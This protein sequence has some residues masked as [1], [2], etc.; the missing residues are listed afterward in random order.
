MMP[1]LQAVVGRETG[2]KR[3]T[4]GFIVC[5][6]A[7]LAL[8]AGA[9]T[10]AP[11]FLAAAQARA[12]IVDETREKYFSRLQPME[13]AAKTGRPLSATTL[14]AQRAETRLRYKA[15]VREFS[16]AEKSAIRW[17]TAAMQPKL[18]RAYPDLARTPWRFIKVA[19][20]IEGG[21]PHTRGDNI[22]LSQS[23]VEWLLRMKANEP[24]A[25][26]LFNA[27]TILVHELVHVH[28]RRKP[29]RYA[30]LY[31]KD[32]GFVKAVDIAIT[33]WMRTYQLM[34]PDGTD[35][36]WV[37]PVRSNGDVRWILPLV[38]F[39]DGDG[40][41]RMPRDMRLIAVT[42]RGKAGRFQ[43]VDG[44]NG[45]DSLRALDA[46]PEFAGKFF[47][48]SSI[49]HPNEIAADFVGTLFALDE[50][51]PKEQFSARTRAATAQ[52]FAAERR[53]F[54]RFYR[55]SPAVGARP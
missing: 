30:D 48:I 20:N 46:V 44:G 18:E 14:P 53:L 9:A 43:V 10:N 28:Q 23:R 45:G 17:Y 1:W 54:R 49:F 13:M 21:L 51:F 37:Y 22:I 29:K 42:L 7:N 26:A 25:K 3:I 2:M 40:P 41:K 55:E 36:T 11:V 24:E 5:V 38:A 27:G 52:M 16:A 15:G 8:P 4:F 32:W 47:G 33:D 35:V 39:S 31:R 19:D 12:A 50:L 34:N 6:V